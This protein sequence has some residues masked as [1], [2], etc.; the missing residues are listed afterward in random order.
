[1]SY[2]HYLATGILLLT[3]AIATLR[4]PGGEH[5]VLRN[6]A[7]SILTVALVVVFTVWTVDSVLWLVVQLAQYLSVPPFSGHSHLVLPLQPAQTHALG[8]PVLSMVG[9]IVDHQVL[10]IL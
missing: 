8:Q 5:S 6:W 9:Y 3:M 2:Y 7:S 4:I 1:M 10:D